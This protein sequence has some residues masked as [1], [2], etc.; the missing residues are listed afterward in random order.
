MYGVKRKTCDRESG[1]TWDILLRFI[2]FEERRC[3][4]SWLDRFA[5]HPAGHVLTDGRLSVNYAELPEALARLEAG[6]SGSAQGGPVIIAGQNDVGTI[7]AVLSC[8]LSGRSFYFWRPTMD[9]RDSTLPWD[10]LPEFCTTAIIARCDNATA[11]ANVRYEF[12]SRAEDTDVSSRQAVPYIYLG[13]SGTT[14]RPKLAAY[15]SERLIGN[16][17]NC[18]RRFQI[19]AEDRVLLP[20]PLAHM[21]GFGAAFL[22]AVLAGASFRLLPTVNLL[23]F[24]QAEREFD[25]TVVFLTPALAHQLITA[26]KQGKRYRLTAMGADRIDPESFARYEERHGCTVCVY[27]STEL[28]AI[29]SGSPDD[30]FE[31]RQNSS[32]HLLDDVQLAACP[33]DHADGSATLCFVHPFGMSGYANSRGEPELPADLFR[34]GVYLTRDLG[35]LDAHGDLHVRGRRDDCVKRDGYLVAFADVERAL[36][37]LPGVSRAIIMG[38]EA[39]PRGIALIAFCVMEERPCT[40][41]ELRRACL[42]HLPDHAVPDQ[43]VILDQLPLLSTGKPDRRALHSLLTTNTIDS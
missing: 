5:A 26:R 14:A 11:V 33:D 12:I 20:L 35:E 7:I 38:G 42:T 36:E 31:R 30:S 37:S 23:T 28:G 25:P 13:T 15:T 6:A 9:L 3:L 16:A 2:N 41:T 34:D 29:A 10:D 17:V 32:G 4:M 18:V 39:T 24:L 27:G 22:P 40:A 1:Y 43:F 19:T 8:L 21:Y